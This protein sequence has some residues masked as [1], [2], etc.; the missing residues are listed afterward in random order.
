MKDFAVLHA[1]IFLE[2]I[3]SLLLQKNKCKFYEQFDRKKAGT[4]G[5]ERP[6]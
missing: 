2:F 1:F 6:L 4:A 5:V 3:F